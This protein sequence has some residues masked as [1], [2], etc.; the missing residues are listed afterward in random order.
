[1]F[2]RRKDGNELGTAAPLKDELFAEV[3]A[4]MFS[5][6]AEKLVHRKAA[7]QVVDVS[8]LFVTKVK[9]RQERLGFDKDECR[10]DQKKVGDV[11]HGKCL[12][13][14]DVLDIFIGNFRQRKVT[15]E[16]FA[17][18]DKREEKV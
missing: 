12:E 3:D 16:E 17:L 11:V 4:D 13:F 8:L 5:K 14:A 6:P 18:L 2:L 10:G 9:L 1:M 7:L 15:D